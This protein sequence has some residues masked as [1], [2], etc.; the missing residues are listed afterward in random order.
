MA[1][2]WECKGKDFFLSAKNNVIFAGRFCQKND[3]MAE[4]KR[5]VEVLL[6]LK[7][8][9]TLTYRLPEGWMAEAGTWVQVPLRGHPALGIVTAVHGNAPVGVPLSAIGVVEGL[10]EAP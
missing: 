3:A 9:E 7:L 6:P 2:D 4:E 5:Y 1:P 8:K 10:P